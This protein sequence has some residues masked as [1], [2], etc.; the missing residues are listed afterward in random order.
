HPSFEMDVLQVY[1]FLEFL[2]I[3]GGNNVVVFVEQASF[4]VVL[5]NGA[6][7]PTVRMEICELGFVELGVEFG[8]A[9]L[10]KEINI[11][12]KA[13]SGGAFRV[14][15]PNFLL[16]LF[17]RVQLRGGVHKLGVDFVVPPGVSEVG[18]DHVRAGMDVADDALA[19]G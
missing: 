15:N 7:N 2:R 14:A 17:T 4:A 5:I 8:T 1:G 13:A 16:L 19:R 9:D 12:P 18:R 6:E 11:A 3:V 10:V